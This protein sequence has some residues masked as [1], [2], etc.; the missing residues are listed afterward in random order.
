MTVREVYNY[1]LVELNKVQAPSVL[2]D[3]FVYLLNKAI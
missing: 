3:D 1:V 2:L